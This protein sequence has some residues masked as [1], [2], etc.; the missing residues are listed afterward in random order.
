[1]HRRRLLR[2]LHEIKPNRIR[3]RMHPKRGSSRNPPPINPNIQAPP[4]SPPHP[5]RLTRKPLIIH[6]PLP[7]LI[8]QRQ[9]HRKN[10]IPTPFRLRGPRPRIA[11]RQPIPKKRQ[12][13][14]KP[15]AVGRAE[16]SGVIPPLALKGK[17]RR[18]IPRKHKPPRQP[19]IRKTLAR[20]SRNSIRALRCGV[21]CLAGHYEG[22]RSQ[23]GESEPECS[24]RS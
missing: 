3:R 21:R 4:R 8:S 22:E 19:R 7:A 16:M 2:H 6:E 1:M 24:D 17:M 9:M 15:P 18:M 14:P 11:R 5:Q 12:L 20:R 10:L 13:I 23:D